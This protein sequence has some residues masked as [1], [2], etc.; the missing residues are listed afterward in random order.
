MARS[1]GRP[2]KYPEQLRQHVIADFYALKGALGRDPEGPEIH[3]RLMSTVEEARE[4]GKRIPWSPPVPSLKWVQ[5]VLKPVRAHEE[6]QKK[7]QQKTGLSL[8]DPWSLGTVSKSKYRIPSEAVR[9]VLAAWEHTMVRGWG[10]TIRQ[11]LWVARLWNL[12]N[13]F[14]E[15][16]G[17]M[18]MGEH[19]HA[20][21]TLYAARERAASVDGK[22]P[23]TT[24][25]DAALALTRE[26]RE[27]AVAAGVVPGW[28]FERRIDTLPDSSKL[29]SEAVDYVVDS[30]ARLGEFRMVARE[31][32][33]I[34]FRTLE[35]KGTTWPSVPEGR[36]K[37]L[38]RLVDEVLA[39]FE[40]GAP[41]LRARP[42]RPFIPTAQLMEEVG[43]RRED[44]AETEGRTS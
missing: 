27:A 36:D 15:L 6:R 23:D 11:A 7:E 42:F 41:V 29:S 35:E 44:A 20:W 30:F 3:R 13:R 22:I 16:R 25:L 8:D 33:T 38:G 39:Y 1:R 40:G 9:Y 43:Y 5:N 31:V 28:P 21:A 12:I 10:F 26:T 17:G 18:A 37:V 34:W 32:W 19:W 14:V 4:D 24:D 2:P